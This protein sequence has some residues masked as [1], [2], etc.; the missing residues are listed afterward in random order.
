MPFDHLGPYQIVGKLGRGGMGTVYEGVHRESGEPAAVK[1]LAAAL[2]QEE[3]FR[4]RFESE[5]E[6]LRKLNHPN[7]VRL[8]GFGEQD[9][10]LFYAMEL[11]D[12]NSLEEE[13]QRGR[14]FDW[15]EAAGIGIEM[16]LALRHAHDRGIVHR[17]IKPGNL[18][19]AKDGHVK[20]SDF[21][22]A[23]LFGNARLTND[24][25]VLGTA[26]YMAPEQAEGRPVEY[27]ADLYSLGA[28]LY[29]LLARRPVFRGRS[30][31]DVLHKQRYDPPDPIRQHAPEVPEEFERILTQLLEKEPERRIPNAS[32]LGRR[33]EEMLHALSTSPET[34]DASADWFE[35]AAPSPPAVQET[36]SVPPPEDIPDEPTLHEPVGNLPVT[37]VITDSIS[38][39]KRPEPILRI[40]SP[41]EEKSIQPPADT[42][43]SVGRFIVVGEDELDQAVEEPTHHPIISFQTWAL[44]SALLTL[45]L[46]AWWFLR[47]PTADALFDRISTHASDKSLESLLLAEPDINDFLLRFSGDI[48]A[49]QLRE[50][51]R[52][53]DLY[54]LEK[55]FDRRVRGQESAKGL[56]PIEQLYLEAITIARYDPVRGMAKLQAIVDLNNQPGDNAGPAGQCL[57]LAKRKLAQLQHQVKKNAS[58][59][60]IAL[61]ERLQ[62][63]DAMRAGDPETAQAMY[64]AV[65]EL[66]S[67]KPWAA[68]AV[69]L[70]RKALN[71]KSPSKP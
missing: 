71:E 23:R 46:I 28:L 64:R 65:V 53:I 38:H 24:G 5:I 8:F 62:A 14:R 7:I 34:L 22:I 61:K 69:A 36:L 20:L 52:E 21:G 56:S 60:L 35:Q 41:V 44:A 31:L 47:P 40:S 50:Y 55:T 12:G 6:T 30:L 63:A 26:E 16:C 29:A 17:D 11:V 45:G 18:L 49:G 9:G 37:E 43:P 67:E 2:A 33:L 42:F 66:Y 27:R 3:G 54:R 51:A 1:L 59:Q 70:A 13:L 68:E 15:R 25:N 10:H 48:R 58:D 4:V 19:M 39:E 32:V 57:T